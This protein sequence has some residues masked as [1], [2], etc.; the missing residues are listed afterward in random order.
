MK[1]ETECE[2][3]ERHPVKDIPESRKL[4]LPLNEM[5]DVDL[6]KYYAPSPWLKFRFYTKETFKQIG[7]VILGL[8]IPQLKS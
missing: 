1:S 6:G 2:T 3:N 7:S 4:C 8:F 5:M